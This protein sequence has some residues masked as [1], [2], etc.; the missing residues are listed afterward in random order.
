M[1]GGPLYRS[2]PPSLMGLDEHPGG[3]PLHIG[4]LPQE[5]G[6]RLSGYPTPTSAASHRNSPY[7]N[8]EN[9]STQALSHQRMSHNANMP[10]PAGAACSCGSC[11]S[12]TGGKA[13]SAKTSG[14]KTQGVSTLLWIAGI[15]AIVKLMSSK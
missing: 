3:D 9:F 12:C 13:A 7:H 6:S 4:M 2:V 1:I 15:F 11:G 14:G 8:P 10:M 5:D